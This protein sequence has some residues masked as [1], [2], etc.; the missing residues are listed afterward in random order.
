[1]KVFIKRLIP[2]WGA[3][4]GLITRR[5]GGRGETEM[6]EAVKWVWSTNCSKSVWTV[7]SRWCGEENRVSV[8]SGCFLSAARC[9]LINSMCPPPTPLPLSVEIDTTTTVDDLPLKPHSVSGFYWCRTR[10]TKT[11]NFKDRS[12][13]LWRVYQCQR[14]KNRRV[15]QFH[16][17]IWG[18][19]NPYCSDLYQCQWTHRQQWLQQNL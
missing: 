14:L 6:T 2:T 16:L 10:N 9:C 17:W 15:G 11:S 18:Y 1:M 5:E 12:L 13:S 4:V 3:H 8:F 7:L 19:K